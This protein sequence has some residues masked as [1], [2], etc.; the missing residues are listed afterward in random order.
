MIKKIIIASLIVTASMQAYAQKYNA[1]ISEGGAGTLVIDKN[2]LISSK[3]SIDVVS[4]N[5]H[6][7][8]L[9]GTIKN[10]VAILTEE[11]E[12]EKCI[13][14]F[15]KG[16]GLIDVTY[17]GNS[18]SYY[19]GAKASFDMPYFNI[20]QQ[21]YPAE[22][23][24]A[25]K[26]LLKLY[27]AKKYEEALL[28][29]EPILDNCSKTLNQFTEAWIR[30]DLAI[31]YAKLGKLEQCSKILEPLKEDAKLSIEDMK[32]NYP[33]FEGEM[34][35]PIMKATKTNLKICKVK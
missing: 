15:K 29:L 32:L 19:C 34:Y 21:C 11:G 31:T 16:E 24:K 17:E 10:G 7:C 33:P 20:T 14:K 26:S 12:P 30:N 23:E 8:S 2:N 3:F 25:R 13:V 18:C 28:Q 27:K 22:I 1:Y 6:T 35:V 9:E 4:T 5:A